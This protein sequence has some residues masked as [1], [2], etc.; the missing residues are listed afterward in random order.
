MEKIALSVLLIAPIVAS[1]QLANA[2]KNDGLNLNAANLTNQALKA[3]AVPTTAGYTSNDWSKLK[4]AFPSLVFSDGS[5]KT[6]TDVKVSKF[7]AKSAEIAIAAKGARSMILSVD[8]TAFKK[9][10]DEFGFKSYLDKTNKF[11]KVCAIDESASFTEIYYEYSENV[12]PILIRYEFSSG[13]GGGTETLQIGNQTL[14]KECKKTMQDL[15]TNKSQT[16][17]SSSSP[18]PTSNR[19]VIPTDLHGRFYYET[20]KAACVDDSVAHESLLTIEPESISFGKISSCKPQ[21][22]KQEKNN[23]VINATCWS[24]GETNKNTISITKTS[25]GVTINKQKY[26]KC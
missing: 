9:E 1:A 19:V 24:E 12:K 16:L 18:K 21:S 13:S 6:Y 2:S 4:E 15:A 17:T 8:V 25:G 26:V 22:I 10:G 5:D 3:A 20:K 14:P 23:Y 11:K 7:K